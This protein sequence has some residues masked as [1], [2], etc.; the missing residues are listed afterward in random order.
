MYKQNN[1]FLLRVTKLA[2]FQELYRIFDKK[3][4]RCR[5]DF[6]SFF[7]LLH[8]VAELPFFYLY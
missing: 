2:E 1:D 6:K 5:L 3:R 8:F 7:L 4:P